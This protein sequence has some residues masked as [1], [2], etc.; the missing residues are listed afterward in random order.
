M[1]QYNCIDLRERM[2]QCIKNYVT[3]CKDLG[4]RVPCLTTITVGEECETI[5]L[6]QTNETACRNTGVIFR[7]MSLNELTS[8]NWLVKKINECNNNDLINGIHLQFPFKTRYILNEEHLFNEIFPNK[9]VGGVTLNTRGRLMYAKDKPLFIP[10]IIQSIL[11]ILLIKLD[12]NLE[13]KHVV[14]YDKEKPTLVDLS[15]VLASSYKC[16]VSVL[17]KNTPMEIRR[18]L[19]L[20][21]DVLVVNEEGLTV[22]DDIPKFKGI[23]IIDIG[24]F[25]SREEIKAFEKRFN[26][27]LDGTLNTI[28]NSLDIL[29]D[30]NLVF[31]TCLSHLAKEVQ[32][33]NYPELYNTLF[34]FHL[35]R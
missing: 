35:T 5:P 2:E 29:E 31:N 28:N 8:H 22:I 10:P 20:S 1:K 19:I 26:V 25:I 9:D 27:E 18:N 24:N 7:H 13:G 14:I 15:T 32:F 6:I 16:S 30:I 34:S 12:L 23:N 33:T 4:E 3:K 21:S 17:S 11:D